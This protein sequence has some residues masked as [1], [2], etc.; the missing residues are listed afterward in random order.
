MC[1]RDSTIAGQG[2]AN[3]VGTIL[4][5]AMLLRT[6]LGMEDAAAAVENAVNDTIQA[7]I[8]TFDIAGALTPASTDTVGDEIARRI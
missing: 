7:G 1:I 2:L 5:F 6:S 3:P 8:R 4:S